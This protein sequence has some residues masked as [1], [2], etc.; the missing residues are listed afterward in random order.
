[1]PSYFLA[2]SEPAVYA[3]A[4]LMNERKT[5]WDGVRNF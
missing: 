3:F 4:R 1:M 5:G 2:K